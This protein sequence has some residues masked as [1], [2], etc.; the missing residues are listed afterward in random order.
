MLMRALKL[1]PTCRRQ[2][3]QS[4]RREPSIQRTPLLIKGAVVG[5]VADSILERWV[6]ERWIASWSISQGRGGRVAH[7][8][9]EPIESLAELRHHLHAQA[10]IA[11]PQVERLP[12]LDDHGH[13]HGV[14]HRD[15]VRWL[16]AR[17]HSVHLVGWQGD[18]CW[19]Q[20]RAAHKA[21]E[22]GRL[23]TL[24]GGTV[25]W[26]E[27]ASSTLERE[28]WEE[29]GLSMR[30]LTKLTSFGQIELRYPTVDEDDGRYTVET[31]H[32]LTA[33]MLAGVRPLNRDGEVA[34]FLSLKAEELSHALM[35]DR[36]TLAATGVFCRVTEQLTA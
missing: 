29:A 12:L 13:V 14:V 7:L 30:Q 8:P 1:D 28:T 36:F 24:V 6:D 20:E 18:T 10:W 3:A 5:S 2:W 15:L 9:S 26:D 34:N 27:D 16:G 33:H 31:V 4:A 25:S 22:P 32:C 35:S 23:D 21:E 11:W 19:V 17:T